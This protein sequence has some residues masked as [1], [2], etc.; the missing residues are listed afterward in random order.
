MAEQRFRVWFGESAASEDQLRRIEDI[1]VTQEMDAIWEARMRMVLC[2]DANGAWL[3]WPGDTSEP[4]S[5]V[6]IELD[7]GDGRFIPLI[8]GPL[9]SIDAALDSQPGRSTATAFFSTANGSTSVRSTSTASGKRLIH[10]HVRHASFAVGARGQPF[11]EPAGASVRSRGRRSRLAARA[12]NT[13]VPATRARKAGS[14]S[15]PSAGPPCTTCPRTT[16]KSSRF[17]WVCSRTHR[18]PRRA[19]LYTKSASTPG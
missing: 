16:R 2:L 3:H 15:V 4:F 8:D 12:A 19:T 14:I 10:A 7:I 1:E 13:F 6:R 5:R 18:F 9:V 11:L 17:P